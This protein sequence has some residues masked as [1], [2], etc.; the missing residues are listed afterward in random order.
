VDAAE[1]VML[2][3]DQDVDVKASCQLLEE[4]HVH[5]TDTVKELMSSVEAALLRSDLDIEALEQVAPVKVLEAALGLRARFDQI[6]LA[7]QHRRVATKLESRQMLA[8]LMDSLSSGREFAKQ[9][10]DLEKVHTEK[11]YRARRSWYDNLLTDLKEKW[12]SYHAQRKAEEEK[13]QQIKEHQMSIIAE[14]DHLL[15]VSYAAS[16]LA[17]QPDSIIS[18]WERQMSQLFVKRGSYSTVKLPQARVELELQAF[19][20]SELDKELF[21][22]HRR[23]RAEFTLDLDANP[24]L[25]DGQ[26]TAT[27]VFTPQSPSELR[28]QSY[29]MTQGQTLRSQVQFFHELLWEASSPLSSD[30]RCWK[31]NITWTKDKSFVKALGSAIKGGIGKITSAIGLPS[32]S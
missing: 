11:V 16:C 6:I 23:F 22:R 24:L 13:Q 15:L 25:K 5:S 7:S 27:L 17:Q 10:E 31:V 14:V 1:S 20:T 8:P 26:L 32:T 19:S 28:A 21:E 12:T 3:L 2:L 29:P 9:F 4:Y 30:D 18:E